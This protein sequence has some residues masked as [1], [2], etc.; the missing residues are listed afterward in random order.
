MPSESQGQLSLADALGQYKA[1]VETYLKNRLDDLPRNDE[2]LFD[3]MKYGLLQG[4]KRIRPFLVY[5]TGRLADADLN[6][7]DAPAAALECIHS[8]SLIHDDLPAMDDDDLRRGQP[9]VHIKYDE[10]T[11]ILAGDSLQAL[12]FEILTSHPFIGTGPQNVVQ[13]CQLLA[14][15]SG[16]AGMCGGQALDLFN[17][18]IA[19]DVKAL[20]QMHRLKT[21][22]L[23]RAAVLMGS[24]CTDRF[25]EQ[26]RVHLTRFADAIG[27]AFQ[28]QDDILDVVG[29]TEVIGKPNGS[30][31]AANKATYVSILGLE[32]ARSM[33]GRFVPPIP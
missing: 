11:A 25:T 8:Y 24:Y 30:D 1:R 22:A 19:V 14:S 15:N 29:D 21:G 13:L 32:Q 31:E 33:A 10:A 4:G 9:T 28:V 5:A 27:L 7:L 12:A 6:D 2:Q 23:I 26:D 16:Y 20:E 18:D 3:A 17:T